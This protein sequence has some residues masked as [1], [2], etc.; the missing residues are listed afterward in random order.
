M[1]L[2]KS[3]L[4]ELSHRQEADNRMNLV[5][6][7]M[8]GISQLLF[9]QF[10]ECMPT[11]WTLS[12]QSVQ[13]RRFFTASTS[14]FMTFVD[15]M[16]GSSTELDHNRHF[17]TAPGC[18]A[19]KETNLFTILAERGY[20]TR[21]LLHGSID[22]HYLHDRY[23]GAWP[24]ECGDFTRHSEYAPFYQDTECFLRAA[25]ADK[26]NFALYYCDRAS[27]LD[28]DSHEK[29]DAQNFP[30]RLAK[31]YRLLDESTGKLMNLLEK[32]KLLP[33]TLV[34]VVGLFGVD[35]WKH[36]MYNG[37]THAIPPY[38][39]VCWTPMFMHFNGEHK[40][41]ADPLVSMVDLKPTLLPILLQSENMTPST[42]AFSGVDIQRK[43]RK[44]VMT[45]NLFALEMESRG[46]ALGIPKS[47]AITDGEHRLIV[48]SNGG[49]PGE[50]GM[51]LYF[52]SRDPGNTRNFLDFF[53]LNNE[54]L[55]TAFGKKD[56]IHPHFTRTFKPHLVYGI[57]NSYNSMRQ[58]LAEQ[59]HLKENLASRGIDAG[60]SDMQLIPVECFTR[61]RRRQ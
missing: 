3:I 39:D 12:F 4:P 29:Q 31:G 34:L 18:L 54:G 2:Q 10:R 41:I 48:T 27:R 45:Q 16:H 59:V 33:N 49:I 7:A 30:D 58:T 11:L 52:D 51:E 19:G 25:A 17:P 5:I 47:Y 44:F 13:F 35:P 32:F 20:K 40:S 21:G 61:K 55:I 60:E 56:I 53:Q 15:L 42:N 36:G 38:A 14:S 23:F 57:V 43:S 28:D 6:V 37:H 1:G 8:E 46:A 24:G 22:S 50:G 26:K 9:W